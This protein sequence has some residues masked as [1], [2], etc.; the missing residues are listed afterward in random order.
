MSLINSIRSDIEISHLDLGYGV[1]EHKESVLMMNRHVGVTNRSVSWMAAP[2]GNQRVPKIC[3]APLRPRHG[4]TSKASKENIK[5]LID[6]PKARPQSH[7]KSSCFLQQIKTSPQQ[8]SFATNPRGNHS[9]ASISRS[10]NISTR[11]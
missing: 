8:F 5:R 3:T 6:S 1:L 11:I 9:L 2:H 10:Q 4:A 7:W